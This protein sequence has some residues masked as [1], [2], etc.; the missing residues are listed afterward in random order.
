VQAKKYKVSFDEEVLRLAVHG[1]LH[2]MGYKDKPKKNKK[3]MTKREDF[4]IAKIFK[5]DLKNQQK[6]KAS[7]RM[8]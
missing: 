3:K 1:A 6:T 2:L 4:Y 7:R 8:V 5:R